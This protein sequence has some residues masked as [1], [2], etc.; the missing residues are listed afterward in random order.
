MQLRYPA[1][2]TVAACVVCGPV[3]A[4]S[5]TE[6]HVWQ[7]KRKFEP[8]S[9]TAESITGTIRL[10]GNPDFAAPGSK[11]AITFGNGKKVGLTSMGASWRQWDETSGSKATAEVFKLSSDPGA[12]RNGNTLCGDPKSEP[13][14]YV[15]FLEKSSYGA[16]PLLGMAVF[17]SKDA[18]RDIN[19][20]NLC[21]TFNYGTN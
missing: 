7:D 12:L 13:A 8:Y 2:F 3:L 19:S 15:V 11:M 10:S 18:P 1:V 20:P 4:Q 5:A 6:H 14:R 21:G 16:S 9:R 17:A